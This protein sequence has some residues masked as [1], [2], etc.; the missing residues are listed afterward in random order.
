MVGEELEVQKDRVQRFAK[1]YKSVKGK[2]MPYGKKPWDLP[3]FKRV[4]IIVDLEAKQASN[5]KVLNQVIEEV[6]RISGAHPKIMKSQKNDNAKGFRIGDAAGVKVMLFGPL[7]YDF[8]ERFNTL[9]LPRIRDFDGLEDNV[10]RRGDYWM[11]IADQDP[12]RELDELIDTREL[13]H[14]FRIG[15]INNCFTNPD[16]RK[17][18]T[19]FG[20]PFNEKRKPYVRKILIE[21]EGEKIAR[22]FAE[23][24]ASR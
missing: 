2:H 7:M 24:R 15:I 10:G 11:E 5:T 18:M 21:T 8:L 19:D 9:V 22:G 6:R 17:L 3:R 13:T 20:F 14:G 16:G 23:K 1:F 12:F 4:E